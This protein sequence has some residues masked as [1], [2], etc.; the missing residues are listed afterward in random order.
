MRSQFRCSRIEFLLT[1]HIGWDLGRYRL[2]YYETNSEVFFIILIFALMLNIVL[3][4]FVASAAQKKG[5]SFAAFF[6][7]SFLIS[8]VIAAIVVAAMAPMNSSSSKTV[9]RMCPFC[10][11]PISPNAILC[12]HCGQQ[13]EAVEVN[14][15]GDVLNAFL[16]KEEWQSRFQDRSGKMPKLL[17]KALENEVPRADEHLLWT[18]FIDEDGKYL[19]NGYYP[20]THSIAVQGWYICE[21]AWIRGSRFVVDL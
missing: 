7:I 10:D 6:F 8:F 15:H 5:R 3:S 1:W 20:S 19:L 14:G 21:T 12:K 13:V 11:E 2:S 9:S 18:E 4:L 17:G 16:S